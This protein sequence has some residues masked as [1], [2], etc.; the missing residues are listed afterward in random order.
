MN[1]SIVWIRPGGANWFHRGY[2]YINRVLREIYRGIKGRAKEEYYSNG[3]PTRNG[4]SEQSKK[5]GIHGTDSD[6]GRKQSNR[7]GELLSNHPGH[8]RR[9]EEIQERTERRKQELR[10][11]MLEIQK[12][13][14]HQF[15]VSGGQIDLIPCDM[16]EKLQ[17]SDGWDAE[18]I[19]RDFETDVFICQSEKGADLK[20]HRHFQVETF[21]SVYGN[22]S[23]ESQDKVGDTPKTIII[24]KDM[25]KSIPSNCNHTF[26]SLTKGKS[27]VIFQPPITKPKYQCQEKRT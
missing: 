4:R 22:F 26:K 3:T 9:L 19:H 23:C 1:V 20:E 2:I 10:D 8:V 6:D 16:H 7:D 24:K 5:P 15:D 12:E 14:L 25:A 17:I 18:L 11:L 13:V 27:L 21:L